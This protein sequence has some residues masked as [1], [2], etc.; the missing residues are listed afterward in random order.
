MSE[1]RYRP[2]NRWGCKPDEDVCVQHDLPLECRHGCK[3]ALSHRCKDRADQQYE[4]YL[5]ARRARIAEL[6]KP[7]EAKV[8]RAAELGRNAYGSH[9]GGGTGV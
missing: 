8:K 4:K 6:R 5:A 3:H 7:Y 9:A 1:R 2:P